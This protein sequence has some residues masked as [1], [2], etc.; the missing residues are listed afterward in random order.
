VQAP[1]EPTTVQVDAAAAV[2]MDRAVRAAKQSDVAIVVAGLNHGWPF[3]TEGADRKDMRL[4]Y[5]Q[6]ELIRRVVEAN[7]RTIVVLVSGGAVEMS[8]WVDRVPAIVQAWYPG[9][10]GGNALASVL[11][12]DVNPSGKLPCTFPKR[13]EDSPAH[14]LHAYP[15]KD[16]VER[17]DEGL[18]VGYRWFDTK[19]IDPLFPFGHGL[20]YTKF[21]YGNL[22]LHEVGTV[23]TVE[24]DIT[25]TGDRAG[26]EVVQ[27]YV[28]PLR[29]VV[30]RPGKELKGFTKASLKPGESQR[31]S[32]TLNARSF[33]YYDATKK[34]WIA[35]AGDYTILIGGSS[36]DIR[37]R[38]NYRLPAT[39]ELGN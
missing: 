9:L 39:I 8:E 15:G 1:A 5:K 17:Y 32:I 36:R 16:G 30:E 29:P 21:E 34:S 13:L 31:V 38:A 10:E 25:N 11:F 33:A 23:L 6:D 37:L 19:E 24:A 35:E 3:D 26:A 28:Q 18:L 22:K 27:V 20:S 14:A 12:G 4:P 2:M 7:P